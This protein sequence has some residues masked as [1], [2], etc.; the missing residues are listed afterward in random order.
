[1]YDY[2][3]DAIEGIDI[4]L[5]KRGTAGDVARVDL[6]GFSNHSNHPLFDIGHG[7]YLNSRNLL[8]RIGSGR[9][10]GSPWAIALIR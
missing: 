2:P 5:S 10:R 3:V 6:L 4:Q 9:D 8:R 7:L 1:M